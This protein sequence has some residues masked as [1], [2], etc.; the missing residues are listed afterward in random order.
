M[1]TEFWEK[2]RPQRSM[3]HDQ[4]MVVAMCLRQN[5]EYPENETSRA[6]SHH[7]AA[8]HGA[9]L[10]ADS[11]DFLRSQPT[12]SQS[13]WFHSE[14]LQW[15]CLPQLGRLGR[16]RFSPC[17]AER[18]FL[19]IDG[20]VE[21]VQAPQAKDLCQKCHAGVDWIGWPYWKILKDCLFLTKIFKANMFEASLTMF[22]DRQQA[23]SVWLEFKQHCNEMLPGCQRDTPQCWWVHQLLYVAVKSVKF[24]WKHVKTSWL[25]HVQ[26]SCLS[27]IEVAHSTTKSLS[28]NNLMIRRLPSLSYKPRGTLAM[29]YHPQPRLPKGCQTSAMFLSV[30]CFR[31]AAWLSGCTFP[32]NLRTVHD[33]EKTLS[34]VMPPRDNKNPGPSKTSQQNH[35]KWVK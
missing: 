7:Q 14:P 9:E 6:V 15:R 24:M 26:S 12:G 8:K 1:A 5:V 25:H 34:M 32:L 21:N 18:T 33:K 17:P 29:S 31:Q 22:W 2:H 19:L 28:T 30:S 11:W 10:F 3:D 20:F 35:S 16:P 23:I 27:S 4:A 13:L